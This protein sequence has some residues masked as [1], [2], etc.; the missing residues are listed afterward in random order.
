V[1]QSIRSLAATSY[2]VQLIATGTSRQVMGTLELSRQRDSLVDMGGGSRMPLIGS[3]AIH[4]EHV[5]ALRLG[6]L[7][8]RDPRRPGVVVLE[9][10]GA[11]ALDV[12]LRFGSEANER[13]RVRFDRRPVTS[14]R[15]APASDTR[16]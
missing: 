16:S 13:G 9:Q 12:M 8:S 6:D 3:A 11:A 14:A 5:G 7:G 1:R 10:G 2:D 4:V 15:G